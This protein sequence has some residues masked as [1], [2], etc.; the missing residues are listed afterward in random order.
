MLSELLGTVVPLSLGK[1]FRMAKPTPHLSAFADTF[2]SEG[3]AK[4]ALLSPLSFQEMRLAVASQL[5]G[6]AQEI[7]ILHQSDD[8]AEQ[9]LCCAVARVF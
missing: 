3:K 5:R 2:P 6:R 8:T 9:R 4:I 7:K 1:R